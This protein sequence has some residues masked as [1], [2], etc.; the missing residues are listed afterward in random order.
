M[1]SARSRLT[2]VWRWSTC[3]LLL[4]GTWASAHDSV[5]DTPPTVVTQA[6]G[7]ATHASGD[8]GD[9]IRTRLA[10]DAD[11]EVRRLYASGGD[12]PVWVDGPGRPSRDADAALLLLA[13]AD[14]DG[15]APKTYHHVSLSR[16]A[17]TLRGSAIVPADDVARFDLDLSRSVLRY[18]RHLHTGRIN[19]RTIGFNLVAPPEPH[20]FADALRTALTQQRVAHLR[21]D[22]A[23]RLLQYDALRAALA[24]YRTLAATASLAAPPPT[25]SP[26]RPGD[27]YAHLERLRAWLAALGDIDADTATSTNQEVYDEPIVAAVQRFQ[28]RHGLEPDGIIGRATQAALQ[29]PLTARIRQIELALE[30]LRWLPDLDERRVV[31][32]N[33]PMFQLWGWDATTPGTPP[34]VAMRA[35]VGRALDTQT[36]VFVAD[37]SQVIFRPYWNVPRS[38]LLNELLP[39]IRR[40]ARYLERE[41]LEIVRG[42][43]DNA[44][45]VPLSADA[46]A[47]LRNGTLRLRQRPG[48]RNALGRVKFLF[49]NSNDVYMHDTPSQSLFSRARRDFS[50]GCVRVEDPVSLAEWALQEQPE[51]TRGRIEEAMA[52][53][54]GPL[55]VSLTRPIRVMIFYTT[56]AVT[57]RDGAVHFVSDIYRHDAR[58]D[59]ALTSAGAE[60]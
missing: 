37:M 5:P 33:I 24:R 15:L 17:A 40:D 3:A 35:I 18:V 13:G 56:A 42:G 58:L 25:T 22:W 29:V 31:L 12:A 55:A 28:A 45:R 49:P 10:R 19:P 59:A 2:A 54:G 47:G 11:A 57:P 23:P 44:V 9:A 16:Q 38:I 51:W 21:E 50:H 1:A 6:P 32:V 30:R 60:K 4:I 48:P 34:V 20:D 14:A 36:P 41:A 43:G 26:V 53:S 27:A 46:L 52:A 39:K 8:V 7:A